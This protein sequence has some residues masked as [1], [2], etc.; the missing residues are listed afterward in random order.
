MKR[1]FVLFAITLLALAGGAV[2]AVAAD[3]APVLSRIVDSGTLR[4]GM[5]GTQPPFSVISKSGSLIGYEV[6]LANLLAEA[7]GVKVEFVQKPFGELLP[8]LEKGEIDAIMSGMTMTPKRNL[9]AA[10][11]G[12]YIVS[13][14]SILTTSSA[15]AALQ[16]A[17]EIDRSSVKITA[18][19]GSTS[20]KFVQKVL[21]KTTYVGVDDYD[22]AVQMVIDGKADALV[23]DFPICAL[24]QMRFPDAGLATLTEPLTIEPIGIA[25]A[26]GDALF[27]NM[28]TNYLSALDGIGL[29][30]ALEKKWF[31]DGSWLIQLP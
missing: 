16:D 6:D 31:E 11:V 3:N 26:P 30:D 7:M 2:D 27:V 8:A 18:L 22:T 13:G 19:K 25:L 4:V 14:K 20:E 5:S 12:P 9:K 17:E 10:F 29:L 21:E 24:S 23:A 1:S 15:L 28:V